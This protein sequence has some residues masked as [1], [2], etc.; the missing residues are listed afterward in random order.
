MAAVTLL[1]SVTFNTNS[2]TKTVTATPAVGDLIVI[3]TAHTNN[4]SL[5]TPTDN[6]SSGTYTKINHALGSTDGGPNDTTIAVHIRDTLIGAAN[7]TVFTHAPGTTTGGGLAVFK[8]TGMSLAGAAAALQ[9]AWDEAVADAPAPVLGATPLTGNALIGAVTNNANPAA[10]TVPNNG[11]PWPELFDTGYNSPV[12]GFE[13][14]HKN[15][16]ATSATITWGSSTSGVAIVV[17]LDCRVIKD[18]GRAD[19]TDTAL[20]LSAKLIKAV[21]M[22]TETSTAFGLSPKLIGATGRADETDTALGLAA[23]LVGATGRADETDTAF[24]LELGAP[25]EEIPIGM[26]EEVD[27]AFGLAPVLIGAVGQADETDTAL[28]LSAL[29][30]GTVGRADEADSALG[31]APVLVQATGRADEVNTAFGLGMAVG[32]GRA[33]EVSTAFGLTPA[34]AIALGQAE[35]VDTALGLSPVLVISLGRADETSTAYGLTPALVGTVGLAVET[36][37]ALGL[38][39]AL[40]LGMAVETNS[41]FGLQMLELIF[42]PTPPEYIITFGASRLA[43]RTITFDQN[44]LTDRTLTFGANTLA[45]RSIDL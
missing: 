35:E 38:G 15:S 20:G 31:L 29:L 40:T 5:A 23:V 11:G 43:D 27:T 36:D 30:L 17:E 25:T 8:V 1:G 33:D 28:G 12:S 16:G 32:V 45:L 39:L 22:A 3:I 6:N 26:A 37:T 44:Q 24:G 10:M 19:E 21:G 41:A 34:Y 42:T 18:L 2:G 14:T 13:G 7:S 9:S 4:D